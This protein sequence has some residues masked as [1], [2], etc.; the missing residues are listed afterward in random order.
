MHIEI[1]IEKLHQ[2]TYM[3]LHLIEIL[4]VKNKINR[5]LRLCYDFTAVNEGG[6]YYPLIRTNTI[7]VNP[8]NCINMAR[9]YKD[10][11]D[12]KENI[13]YFGYTC[14]KSIFGAVL[15]EFSHFLCYQVY[16]TLVDDYKREFPNKRL[17]LD[18][19]SNSGLEEELANI[20][21][22]YIS[23]PYLLKLVD[24]RHFK[25]LKGYFKSPVSSSNNSC[26][27]IYEKF[28]MHVKNNLK[29]KWNIIYN[30]KTKKFEKIKT[31]RTKEITEV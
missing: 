6:Y 20:M 16:K 24:E 12:S 26:F 11:D 5:V 28:P 29:E 4:L 17:M 22:L 9:E 19:Y 23:N 21:M 7:F 14:D 27:H 2:E 1:A 8:D 15:H 18:N 25:F 3:A 30:Y 31:D 10:E 13:F